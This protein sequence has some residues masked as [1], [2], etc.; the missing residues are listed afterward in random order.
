MNLVIIRRFGP[1]HVVITVYHNGQI[2]SESD[3]NFTTANID[4][5]QNDN[6]RVQVEKLNAKSRQLT[7]ILFSSPVE[8]TI[9]KG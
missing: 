7:S 9:Y 1:G 5:I 4:V 3:H 2:V 6:G 8:F